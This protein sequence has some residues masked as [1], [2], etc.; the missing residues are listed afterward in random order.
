MLVLA[1]ILQ[2]FDVT[3]D[4][5]KYKPVVKQAL[6]IKPDDLYIRVTPRKSMDATAMDNHIHSNGVKGVHTR[7]VSQPDAAVAIGKPMTILYGSNTGTCQAFAQRLASDAGAH[8]FQAEVRNLDSATNALPGDRP[9]VII[10]SS[11]EGQ[12]PDNAA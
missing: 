11:Y 1:M 12:P 6:T 10:T 7:P 4:D 8:G 5:P 3:L 2:N 9:V